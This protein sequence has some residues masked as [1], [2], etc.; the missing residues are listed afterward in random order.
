MVLRRFRGHVAEHNWFAVAVDFLIVV[1]GV[2]VGIQASNWNQAR[3]ERR[4]GREYRAMLI[5]DLQSNQKNLAMRKRYY[6]WVRSEALKTLAALDRPESALDARFLVDAYQGTQILPWSLKRNTYD[7]I[8]A[9]GRMDEL[10]DA[11]LRDKISNYY[12]GAEVTGINLASVMPY[13]DILRRAMPYVAQN[14]IRTVCGEKISE[15]SRGE[16]IMVLPEN[17]SVRLDPAAL[18]RAIH[19]VWDTPDLS[20]DLNRQLVDLDQKL[21]S[22]D[23]IMRRAADLERT[24]RRSN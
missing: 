9:A 22:V 5:D 7:Q 19:Q 21:V 3:I 10:G 12:V 20:L 14:Q 13:R 4:Q 6:T 15:D 1:I 2:F 23:V 17:C 18:R 24:L 11:R 8:I 16:A